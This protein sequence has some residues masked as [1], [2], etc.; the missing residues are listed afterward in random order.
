[1]SILRILAALVAA[2][3]TSQAQE[4]LVEFKTGDRVLIYGNSYAQHLQEAG[5]FEAAIQLA[6][7]EKKLKFRNLAWTGDTVGYR[8]RPERY[9]NHLKNLLAAWPANVV[10]LVGFGAYESFDGPDGLPGFRDSLD[11][12]LREMKRRHPDAKLI[13]LLTPTGYGPPA[14]PVYQKAMRETA[15]RHDTTTLDLNKVP[16]LGRMALGDPGRW[17]AQQIVGKSRWLRIDQSRLSEIVPAVVQKAA[18][19]ATL[20]RPINAV[21]YFGVRGR[22]DE[23]EAEMPRYH[24]MVR[25]S[26]AVIHKLVANPG[27]RFTDLPRPSLPPMKTPAKRGREKEGVIFPPAEQ[28]KTLSVA[29]GYELNLFASESEF[30]DMKNPVQIAFGPK[31]RLWVVTMPSFPH[32]IP[33]SEPK[34]K[35]L[36]LE[37]TDQDGKADKQTVFADGLNVPDGIVF[38]RDGVIVSAQPRLLY[39]WDRDG[40]GKADGKQELLRGIDVTDAHHG[41]MIAMDPLG[42]I[43]LCDG[44]FH[45]SQFETPDGIVRGIDA[46]TYRFDPKTRRIWNEYQTI[47]PNP[48][49]I[50][51]DR[52][53]NLFHMYGDGFVQDSQTMPWTPLGVYHDFKRSI[54]IA[55]GKGSG[56]TVISS[57]NFPDE[58]QQGMSSATLLGKYFVALSKL[59][60]S[61]GFNVASDRLDIVSSTNAAFRPV[62]MAFGFDGAMYISDFCSPIVGHAQHPMRDP[63]WDHDHGRIW[64]VTHTGEPTVKEWPDVAGANTGQLLELLA[65]PQDNVR[66]LTRVR[67]RTTRDLT[68]VL[69]RHREQHPDLSDEIQLELLWL[70]ESK[71]KI[72]PDLH[73]QLLASKDFRIRA[74]ATRI[75]RFQPVRLKN[76]FDLLAKMASDPHPRV[77]IEVINAASHLQQLDAKWASLL[78]MVDTRKSPFVKGTLET[79]NRGIAPAKGPEV[80]ILEVPP[81]SRIPNWLRDSDEFIQTAGNGKRDIKE[82]LVRT[83][84]HANKETAAIIS[85]RHKHVRVALNGVQL[86]DAKTWWSSDWNLQAKL[87]PGINELEFEFTGGQ[88]RAQGIAPVFLFDPLGSVIPD[89]TVPK[90]EKSLRHMATEYRQATGAGANTLR[91]AAVPNQLAFAPKKLTIKAGQKVTVQFDNPDHQIHNIV[92][93]KPGTLNAVGLLAD[94]LAFDPTAIKRQYLPESEDIIWSTPLVNGKSEV[95]LEFT[96]PDQ[97]GRYPIL[98]TFPGHWLIMQAIL[99][100]Q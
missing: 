33:G 70:Y 48:W 96:A 68:K 78:G 24:A 42:H 85:L 76:A 4:P 66:D 12:Y 88:R 52:W 56:A 62:D 74:A 98:C 92:I 35:I 5:Y 87:S 16:N 10:V 1:V 60:P 40:D 95:E 13:L 90:D 67:L 39:M 93:C 2:A 53:G 15:D 99:I 59:D 79:A 32:T 27:T 26:D 82:A 14:L 21:I 50:T 77:R 36:I 38:Y 65:Y 30:P 11:S 45:R 91:I 47:T 75:I 49:K 19:V 3:I 37:D 7:P 25:K 9:V 6:H 61:T 28:Q 72:R 29:D 34:D 41:G 20:V 22:R 80:P 64:R 55:Y 18:H 51:F 54:S 57:P 97:P 46:T 17:L 94:K 58:Y 63:R 43:M 86:L 81:D 84:V 69:D 23:Y 100:V 8:L 89:I 31:G 83:Y 44:V 71:N 73:E